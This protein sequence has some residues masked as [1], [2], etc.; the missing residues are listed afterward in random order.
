MT[1]AGGGPLFDIG[2]HCLDTLRAVLDDEV[3]SVKAHLDP[4]PTAAVTETT[5]HLSLRFSRGTPASIFCTYASPVR[6]RMLEVICREAIITLPDFTAPSGTLVVT[7][8]RG[9]EG[10]PGERVVEHFDVPNPYTHEVTLFSDAI[11]H[12]TAHPLDGRNGLANMRVLEE[13]LRQC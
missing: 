9:K 4:V 5:A 12:G 13:A 8:L 2:V 6:I 11:L 3:A 1:V 10:L 7:A